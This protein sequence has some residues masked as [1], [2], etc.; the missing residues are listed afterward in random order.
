MSRSR[1]FFS[2]ASNGDY[3]YRYPGF[4][5]QYPSEED[6]RHYLTHGISPSDIED[7]THYYNNNEAGGDG[8]NEPHVARMSPKDMAEQMHEEDHH[9][10]NRGSLDHDH[11]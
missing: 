7:A 2:A 1:N 6:T 3:S 5:N 11:K 9:E 10:A 8:W 4:E